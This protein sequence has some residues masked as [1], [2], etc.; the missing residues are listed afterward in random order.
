MSPQELVQLMSI[1]S[2]RAISI[3]VRSE[4]LEVF[5]WLLNYLQK[6]IEPKVKHPF[7]SSVLF[8][9][10]QGVVEVTTCTKKLVDSYEEQ[11]LLEKGES[12]SNDVHMDGDGWVKTVRDVPF[13]YLSLDIP[14][15]PL[16]RDS[17]GGLII[18][19]LPLFQ[20]LSKFDGQKWSDQFTKEA[21]HRKQ[22]RI[23]RLPRYLI[24]HLMRF[25]KNNFSLEKNPTIVTFPVRN[26]EMK[27]YLYENENAAT[28][29]KKLQSLPSVDQIQAMTTEELKSFIQ[30]FGGPLHLQE[31]KSSISSSSSNQLD[32]LRFVALR[33]H[34]RVDLFRSTKYDLVSN[35]CHDSEGSA[36]GIAVGDLGMSNV[37]GN[38]KVANPLVLVSAAD[39]D[40]VVHRGHY[41]IHL[42]FKATGQWYELQDLRVS[43]TTPQLIGKLYFLSY[44]LPFL[45]SS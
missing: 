26:L 18:P 16:F 33:A 21:H 13:T 4:V 37:Y 35:I 6:T 3:G 43:E 31:M 24:L 17:Q 1:E 14:P 27:D 45:F 19:Q 23:K 36:N 5:V 15:C 28:I 38:K 32:A 8:E 20:L 29:E 42:P 7:E 30:D 34:E 9:P 40:S 10:F 44:L 22:Y 11:K 12:I 39:L 25:T 2:K 41:K